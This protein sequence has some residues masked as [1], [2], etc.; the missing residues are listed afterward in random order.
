[1]LDAPPS[2]LTAS[3]VVTRQLSLDSSAAEPRCRI[4]LYWIKGAGSAG[5]GGRRYRRF[6]DLQPWAA[7]P[8]A[9]RGMPGM[10]QPVGAALRL[11]MVRSGNTWPNAPAVLTGQRARLLVDGAAGVRLVGSEDI[12]IRAHP[13]SN[14]RMATAAAAR[15]TRTT[16]SRGVRRPVG[17]TTDIATASATQTQVSQSGPSPPRPNMRSRTTTSPERAMPTLCRTRPDRWPGGRGRVRTSIAFN[18]KGAG[19]D[20]DGALLQRSHPMAQLGVRIPTVMQMQSIAPFEVGD[21][22]TLVDL[23]EP[24]HIAQTNVVE[25][26]TADRFV[27]RRRHPRDETPAPYQLKRALVVIVG[28]WA[29]PQ[30]RLA[31]AEYAERWTI[32]QPTLP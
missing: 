17:I 5:A 12:A 30:P 29:K 9:S 19:Y 15:R 22:V 26:V 2:V 23:A 10:T 32:N 27:V 31:P 1:M 3:A 7:A 24:V 21:Q 6:H 14:S 25:P 8:A 20:L 18:S 16:H 13:S 11:L 28:V 4:W